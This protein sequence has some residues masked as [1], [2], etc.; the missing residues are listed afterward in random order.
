V[1]TACS[2]MKS[3]RV[4]VLRIETTLPRVEE[5]TR[6]GSANPRG[7][8]G[9]TGSRVSREE[10]YQALDRSAKA[11]KTFVVTVILS[12]IVAMIGLLRDNPAVVIGAMVIAPLLGPN[13]ALGLAVTLADAA[14]ARRALKANLAGVLVC[15]GLAIPLGMILAQLW[16]ESFQVKE[17]RGRVEPV[18]VDLVLALASGVAGA[19]AFTASVAM[20]LV[21]VMVA[22]A[23]LPPLVVVGLNCGAGHWQDAM[24]AF[25]LL[26]GNVLC[27]NLAS[28]V[29]FLVVGVQPRS[30]WETKRA[31]RATTMVLSLLSLGF[32][33]LLI[34]LW[35]IW[36]RVGG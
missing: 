12:T 28:V 26:L 33:G 32:V 2:G 6:S 17:M 18:P 29:T 25:L 24:N 23:L 36:E 21:G 22:V 8:V 31:R 4:V 34:V 19:M 16:P 14:L 30:W 5:D 10:L 15:L 35:R 27:V 20:S 13:M 1:Q 7:K 11:D 3:F 9:L